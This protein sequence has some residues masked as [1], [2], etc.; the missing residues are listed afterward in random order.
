MATISGALMVAYVQI[1]GVPVE[2]L[3]TAVIMTAPGCIV[4]SKMFVPET[5]QPATLGRVPSDLDDA[6]SDVGGFASR[7]IFA[8]SRGASEGLSLCLQVGAML[9]A[10]VG[11]IALVN[12]ILAGVKSGVGWVW[13]PD[14]LQVVLGFFFA[15][16]AWLLGIPWADAGAVGNLLGTRMVLN[17]FLAYVD[18]NQIKDTLAPGSFLIAA[19]ALCGF[20]NLGSIGVQLGGIGSLI[21]E[22]RKEMAQLGLKAMAAATLAN[23]ITAALAGLIA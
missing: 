14:S 6:D 10:F 19:Y 17:E 4:L 16:V 23:F 15:P 20:A 5:A 1:G 13:L 9:V 7:L 18:L 8:A 21:P 3:L 22:R 12:G 2:H 11:L